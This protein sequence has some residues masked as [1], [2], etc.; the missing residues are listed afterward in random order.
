MEPCQESPMNLDLIIL[1]RSDNSLKVPE[2][3]LNIW[4]STFH[5]F[6]PQ[7]QKHNRFSIN[8]CWEWKGG[9]RKEEIKRRRIRGKERNW[10]R[11]NLLLYARIPREEPAPPLQKSRR[12]SLPDNFRELPNHISGSSAFLSMQIWNMAVQRGASPFP[13]YSEMCGDSGTGAN[14]RCHWHK[15]IQLQQLQTKH[16]GYQP[17]NPPV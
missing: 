8:I 1:P 12:S 17:Q 9:E 7:C 16:Q 2:Y 11:M 14:G 13:F 6:S 15:R 4:G 10:E 3:S 5:L